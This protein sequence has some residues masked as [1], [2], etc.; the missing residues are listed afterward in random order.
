M[1]WPDRVWV[2]QRIE[3]DVCSFSGC[4]RPVGTRIVDVR[5]QLPARVRLF[6][7]GHTRKTDLRLRSLQST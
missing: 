6:D 2:V 4:W 5:A 1:A 7:I 3:G